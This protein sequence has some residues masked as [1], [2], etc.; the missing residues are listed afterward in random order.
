[1][2]NEK[3]ALK[4]DCKGINSPDQNKNIVKDQF[5][6]FMKAICPD[7]VDPDI[8]NIIEK[9]FYAGATTSLAIMC[10]A[11]KKGKERT[12]KKLV[13]IQDE[14]R[15]FCYKMEKQAKNTFKDLI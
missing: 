10:E 14:C 6:L 13:S 9:S 15:E 4:N 2:D 3:H 1:M 12:M 11:D 7:G 8:W 5:E